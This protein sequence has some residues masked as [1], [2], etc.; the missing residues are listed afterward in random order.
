MKLD[1]KQVEA[2]MDWAKDA[3]LEI[4]AIGGNGYGFRV[5]RVVARVYLRE[6]YCRIHDDK[7]LCECTL[8]AERRLG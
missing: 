2:L 6:P 5:E 1:E 8:L 4:A 3:T 7:R